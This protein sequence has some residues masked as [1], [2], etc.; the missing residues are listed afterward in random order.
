MDQ[1][2][3]QPKSAAERKRE[4]R[5]RKKEDGSYDEYLKKQRERMKMKREEEKKKKMNMNEEKVIEFNMQKKEKERVRKALYRIKKKKQQTD[6]SANSDS[7]SQSAYSTKASYGK[8][9]A[10]VKRSLPGNP[11]KKRAVVKHLAFE[12]LKLKP[13]FKKK[14]RSTNNNS[15]KEDVKLSITNFY[16]NDDISRQAPG[17]R[18]VVTVREENSK[19]KYQKR[20]LTMGVIEAYSIWKQEHP[21]MKCGKSAFAKLRPPYV[22]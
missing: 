1:V 17:K 7:P 22:C 3:K 6:L 18:D 4:E 11:S 9:I 10:R 5:K 12:Q 13:F 8:A 19:Q 21:D 2:K 16:L 20:H 14:S 15:I